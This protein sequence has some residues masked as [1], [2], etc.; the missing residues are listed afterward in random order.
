MRR[1]FWKYKTL[2]EMSHDE[3]EALCDGCAQCCSVKL[4][5]E[6]SG[7]IYYT[8]VACHLLDRE[9]CRCTAYV[10][11][12]V[13]VPACVRLSADRLEVLHWMPETCAYRLVDQGRDLPS[14][15]HLVSGSQESVHVA[16]VSVRGRVVSEED[17]DDDELEDHVIRG[18]G[19]RV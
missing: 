18:L 5:D 3:W 17:I 15:H 2:S 4:E 7:E 8:D 1:D 16:G 14:W 6:D 9:E 13:L 19:K 12:S 10:Q 11:R